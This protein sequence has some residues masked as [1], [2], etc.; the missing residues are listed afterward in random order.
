M[1]ERFWRAAR[2]FFELESSQLSIYTEEATNTH[3]QNGEDVCRERGAPFFPQYIY[4]T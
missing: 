4:A 2:L 1:R 3:T